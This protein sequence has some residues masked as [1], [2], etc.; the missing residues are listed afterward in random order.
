[1]LNKKIQVRNGKDVFQLW[2]NNYSTAEIASI[3]GV[4]DKHVLKVCVEKLKTNFLIL[5]G[6]LF[7]AGYKGQKLATSQPVDLTREDVSEIVATANEDDLVK[8]WNVFFEHIGGN[9]P[10]DKK[11]KKKAAKQKK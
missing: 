7:L 3:F 1:M 4:E 11:P 10:K 5:A 8:V 9:E 2:F 6:D